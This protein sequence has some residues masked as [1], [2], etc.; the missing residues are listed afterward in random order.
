[1]VG[2]CACVHVCIWVG[3]LAGVMFVLWLWYIGWCV[4]ICVGVISERPNCTKCSP[5]SK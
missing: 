2:L 3:V 1:M 4:Y 5:V